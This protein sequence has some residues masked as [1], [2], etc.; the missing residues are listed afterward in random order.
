TP[1]VAG[2]ASLVLNT[3]VGSYDL[4]SNGKW[5]PGEVQ[6][7]LQDTAVDKGSAGFDNLYG[8]GLVNAYSAVQ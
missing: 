3:P 2:V 5:D 6:K 1:H 7:K 4:N 8:W